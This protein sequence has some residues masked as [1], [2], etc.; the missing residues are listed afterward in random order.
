MRT[1]YKNK[2]SNKK[3]L[4]SKDNKFSCFLRMSCSSS[5]FGINLGA[6]L[7]FSNLLKCSYLFETAI[8]HSTVLQLGS[9]QCSQGSECTKQCSQSSECTKQCSQGSECT[10][11][12]SQG[13][14][15]LHTLACP[16]DTTKNLVCVTSYFV[17]MGIP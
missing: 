3:C 12:C 17:N 11:Q 15:I 5:D 14:D 16:F 1:L 8:R 2:T 4:S 7:N 13:S 9:K 10:K 6:L